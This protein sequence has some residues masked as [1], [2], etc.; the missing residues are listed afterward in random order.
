MIIGITTTLHES[1]S[2]Q[3]TNFEYIDRVAATGATPVLLP[4][5]QGTPQENREHAR[6]VLVLL[7]GLLITGGGDIHPR[8]YTKAS[9]SA[10]RASDGKGAHGGDAG[11][12]RC[13][14]RGIKVPFCANCAS[15]ETFLRA[16][17]RA[18]GGDVRSVDGRSV[19][20]DPSQRDVPSLS[21]LIAVNENC[22]A[23]ELELAR[24][25]HERAIPCLGICRG[26][27]VM[28]VSLGG[29]LYRDLYNCGV[30]SRSHKQDPP[31]DKAGDTVEVFKGS[32]LAR[33][34]GASGRVAVNSMHHQAIDR[35]ARGLEV[36]AVSEDGVTEAV[37]DAHSPF[38]IGVQWH[39]EYLDMQQGLFDSLAR[40]AR[41]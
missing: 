30:T 20:F 10:Q 17:G 40:A 32:A 28:N 37:E 23:F 34:L 36:S 6:R 29:S 9:A 33:A 22:D 27:Q 3:R 2:F 11:S 18:E 16:Y 35:V 15:D 19:A 25:A 4:P 5:I 12:D 14:V 39:P 1:D 26:M 38:F 7:D 24:L 8:Y 41:S 13:K 21:D 31:Y